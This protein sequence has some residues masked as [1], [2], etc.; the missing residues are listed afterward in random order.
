MLRPGIKLLTD[1]VIQEIISEA[2]RVLEGLGVF[3]E[4]A[5]AAENLVQAGAS[6]SDQGRVLIPASMVK[7]ALETVP[8][9]FRLYDRE[10]ENPLP[11]DRT[12]T[13]EPG[14]ALIYGFRIYES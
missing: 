9:E 3:V 13:Q 1:G 7:R 6:V 8:C 12:G 5:P 11:M 4:Y 10:G 2:E 14:F